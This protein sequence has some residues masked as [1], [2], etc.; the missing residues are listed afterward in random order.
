M[1][2]KCTGDFQDGRAASKT[3]FIAAEKKKDI[4][5]PNL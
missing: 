2:R 1:G 3:S 5:F 4:S